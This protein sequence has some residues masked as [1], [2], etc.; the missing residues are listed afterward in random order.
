MAGFDVKAFLDGIITFASQN[1]I[2][3]LAGFTLLIL[4]SN[5]GVFARIRYGIERALTDNWQLTLLAST[6]IALSLASGYTTFDG[7]RNFTNAPLL[8]VAISFGIQG[9]MLIVAWLI[10]ESFATGMNQRTAEGKRVRLI[11]A[12]VG[13]L[14]GVAFV[15]V[16]FY[17]VLNQSSAVSMTKQAGLQA[18]WVKVIDVSVYFL[19]VMV[20]VG[21]IAF[22]FRRGGDIS[23]PYVQ[24]M[25]LIVKNSVLWVMFLASMASSVFFSF[26]S[27]F[28][29]I[30]PAEQ[31][32]R[33]AEIRT[34]SQIGNVVSDVGAV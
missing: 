20:L 34:T 11:D 22:G 6:G 3:V 8:S 12:T 5:R 30:F 2:L 10:G 31:R 32:K 25:R 4:F 15:G 7:L 1:Y 14:L 19:L 16:A 27:H 29:A 28:N 33:A 21:M 17:W 24:S 26:D 23:T 18:D 9:V 13:M